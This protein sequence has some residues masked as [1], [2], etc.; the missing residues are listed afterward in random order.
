M[1]IEKEKRKVSI[2][3]RDGSTIKGTVHINPGERM[4]D[5]LNDEKESFIP[6]TD[7]ELFTSGGSC[8]LKG[9]G[10]KK[11]IDSAALLNKAAIMFIEED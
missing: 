5:F 3:C 7:V 1:R 6:V 9:F 11:D 4:I 8:A 2:V 10:K